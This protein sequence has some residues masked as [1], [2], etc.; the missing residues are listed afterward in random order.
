MFNRA[1]TVVARHRI[2]T[3]LPK[4]QRVA[5]STELKDK[6]TETSGSG[7]QGKS[8]VDRLTQKFIGQIRKPAENRNSF[9]ATPLVL[10][11]QVPSTATIEDIRKIVRE[12]APKGDKNIKEIIFCRTS[13]F[14]FKGRCLVHLR[15][16][17]DASLLINY[18]HK[19]LLGGRLLTASFMGGLEADGVNKVLS[20]SRAPQLF[21][22]NTNYSGRCV[23]VIGLAPN[24]TVDSVLGVLRTKNIHPVEGF[25]DNVMALPVKIGSSCSKFLVKFESE[26]EAWRCV[27]SFHNN[28]RYHHNERYHGNERFNETSRPKSKLLVSV[29]Y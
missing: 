8:F 23:Q 6:P 20:S 19:R 24:A 3:Q 28:E 27:R 22:E 29:V 10:L 1:L 9:T 4:L 13:T 25:I 21:L 5:Y 12:S 11:D 16:T 15:S 26:A 7:I 2:A 18:A 17:D 14:H